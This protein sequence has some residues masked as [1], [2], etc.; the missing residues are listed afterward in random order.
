MIDPGTPLSSAAGDGA[1]P[2]NRKKRI[3]KGTE[4]IG[5]IRPVSC[6]LALE[7]LQ[8]PGALSFRPGPTGR[9][10]KKGI[11]NTSNLA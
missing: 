1:A 11:D 9:D 10:I 4:N 5:G 3:R 6:S 2:R 7:A 8:A